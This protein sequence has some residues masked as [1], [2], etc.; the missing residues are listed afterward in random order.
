MPPPPPASMSLSQRLMALAET[1]QFA[2]FVGHVTLLLCTLR[3]AL[4]YITFNSYSRWARFSY[5]TAFVAAAATYGIVVFKAV[6]ARQRQGKA[7]PGGAI[8]LAIDE[9]VQYLGKF[10][11]MALLWLFSRQIPLAIL[12]FAV[13][14]TFHVATYTH[15][16]LLPTLQ[17]PSQGQTKQTSALAD[18]IGRFVKEYYTASMTLVAVLEVLLWFRIVGSAILFQKG[19]WILLIF[20]TVFFRIRHSQSNF[21]Q[22]ATKQLTARADAAVAN[23]NTPPAARNIWEQVKGGVRQAA[24]A[25]DVNRFVH[26]PGPPKKAQ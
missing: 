21:M 11:G 7:Q 4:S 2:W 9:N 18:N 5:R 6:R 8:G 14:S 10:P 19:S 16:N 17:P 1:L 13:Y 25:T 12:P 23:Q 20:Y 26:Q 22:D 24:D 15:T 3:Y